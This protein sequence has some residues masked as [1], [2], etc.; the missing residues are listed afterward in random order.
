MMKEDIITQ[1]PNNHYLY[2]DNDSSMLGRQTTR[3][4][5]GSLM[6]QLYLFFLAVSH[7]ESLI[8]LHKDIILGKIEERLLNIINKMSPQ[9]NL[10][11]STVDIRK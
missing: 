7:I 2:A 3:Q 10:K 5:K 1:P 4:G 11:E 6:S 8:C 9:H